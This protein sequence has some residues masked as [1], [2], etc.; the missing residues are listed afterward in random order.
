[1]YGHELSQELTPFDCGLK[2][3][4]KMNKD[5]FIGKSALENYQPEKKLIKFSLAKGIPRSGLKIF[6]TDDN[7]VGHV[8]SGT[9]SPIANT[10]IAMG[11]IKSE[12]KFNDGDLLIDI[13]GKKIPGD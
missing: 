1:L 10:G 3:T 12:N 2:W 4:I 6:D 8:T 9:F 5:N 13:R 11:L 7:E